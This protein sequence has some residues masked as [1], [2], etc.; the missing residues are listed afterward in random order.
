MKPALT[1]ASLTPLLL[2]GL[3]LHAAVSVTDAD[4]CIVHVNRGFCELSG[5]TAEELIG[6]T[7]RL[8]NSGHHDAEFFNAMWRCVAGGKVWRGEI[9]NRRKSGDMYWVAA[10][11]MPEL[12]DIG[13]PCRYVSIR[14]D[15]TAVKQLQNRAELAEERYR[16][17]LDCAGVG[18]WDLDLASNALHWSESVAPLFGQAPCE[19][20]T[21]YESFLAAVHPDD[22]AGLIAAVDECVRQ[23]TG[24]EYEHRCVW[25]DGRVRWLLERGGVSRGPDGEPLHMFGVVQDITARKDAQ[26]QL[27]L[28]RQAV[29]AA[30]EGIALCD[31]STRRFTYLNPAG[32]AILGCAA[33]AVIGTDRLLVLPAAVQPLFANAVAQASRGWPARIDFDFVRPDGSEVPLRNTLSAL[34]DAAGQATHL[35]N[36]FGDRSVEIQRRRVIEASLDEARAANQAKAE[37]MSR[38]SHELRTPLN[39]ILGFSQVLEL[40]PTLDAEQVDS[41]REILQAGRHLLELVDEVLDIARIDLGNLR[42]V[43]VAIPLADLVAQALTMVAP[44]ARERGLELH[45]DID[46]RLCVLA[47]RLRLKQCLINLLSNAVK[48]NRAGGSVR[49]RAR[50]LASQRVRIEVEDSGLGLASGELAQLFEPFSRLER[51]R[52]Q[53]EGMGIGLSITQRLVQLMNGEIGAHSERDSGSVF[54]I[55][56]PGAAAGSAD[57][58]AAGPEGLAANRHIHGQ[59]VLYIEDNAAN[60]KLVR[61]ML[62]LLPAVTVL[63]ASTGADGL[64]LA[65]AELPDLILLD[66]DLPDMNGLELLA[67]LRG[68]PTL[69]HTR[70]IA[71]SAQARPADVEQGLHAGVDDY[72]TKP[73]DIHQLLLRVQAG[74]T[75]PGARR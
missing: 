54:W 19:L 48:Y 1:P 34:L 21:T 57:A 14:T 13:M 29:E 61:S 24:Y 26:A 44:G 68:E 16:R 72:V 64:A 6:R 51:H 37:F 71:V 56:L 74:L 32:A 47:D 62:Q 46:P 69:A 45:H 65:R 3:D 23:G 39:A 52:E 17:S 28:F 27:A 35:V 15:I 50:E 31:A 12:D 22:R 55:E 38:M 33:E 9:R 75:E 53:A 49:L 60:L 36:V 40:D 10:T 58:L 8:L 20:A 67:K 63:G 18:A 4:G 42:V 7:H 43:P 11:I 5:Y 30:S 25:P 73:I 59:R 2:A 66:I 70:V 41:V